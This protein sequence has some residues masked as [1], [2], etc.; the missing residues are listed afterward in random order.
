[1]VHRLHRAGAILGLHYRSNPAPV[2]SYTGKDHVKLFQKDLDSAQA[3]R[4]LVD[5]YVEWAGGIDALVQLS[6]N[7]HRPVHWN[8]MDEEDWAFDLSANLIMPYFCA[9]RAI[10]HMK[11]D[12]GRIILTSTAS[13]AHGGGTTS[14]AYGVAKAGIECVVKRLAR[15]CAHDN[16]LV[17]AIAPGFVSTKFHTERMGRTPADLAERVTLIPLGR[18]GTPEEVAAT[19]LFLLSEGGSYLTGAIIPL[20]GGEWI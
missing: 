18:G 8:E 20:C 5:E 11:G 3:C 9:V 13:A 16:I 2:A 7:I 1:L 14:L 19:I 15:D 6:G 17:N 10:H 12:G 4:E